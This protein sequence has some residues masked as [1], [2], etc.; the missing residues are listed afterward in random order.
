MPPRDRVVLI[1]ATKAPHL[2]GKFKNNSE[3]SKPGRQRLSR[4]CGAW[5][6]WGL[7]EL[8]APHGAQAAAE[9]GLVPSRAGDSQLSGRVGG[10]TTTLGAK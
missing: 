7:T 3:K 2:Q 5:E 10:S 4:A 9:G 6:A 8:L 1:H